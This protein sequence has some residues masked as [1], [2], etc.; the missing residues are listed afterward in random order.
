MR[1]TRLGWIPAFGATMI[2]LSAC[3][4]P[5]PDPLPTPTVEAV[6]LQDSCLELSDVQT[7]TFHLRLMYDEGRLSDLEWQGVRQLAARMVTRIDVEPGSELEP[8]LGALQKLAEPNDSG[9]LGIIDPESLEW[10]EALQGVAAVCGEALGI[11]GW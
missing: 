5:S 6:S 4:T 9:S 7:L 11:Y 2:L 8:K 10:N 1:F 3:A